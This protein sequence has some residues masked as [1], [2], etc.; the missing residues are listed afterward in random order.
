MFTTEKCR[1]LA[2]ECEQ[3]AGRSSSPKF[4]EEMLE[5]ARMW[6]ALSEYKKETL[7]L[8]NAA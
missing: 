7:R 2:E 8:A 5:V 6:R 4:R 3:D 1:R